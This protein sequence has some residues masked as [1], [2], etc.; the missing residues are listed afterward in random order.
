MKNI[1]FLFFPAIMCN[2]Q[3]NNIKI[4]SEPINITR[5]IIS[6][7]QNKMVSVLVADNKDIIEIFKPNTNNCTKIKLGKK[8]SFKVTCVSCLI[9]QGADS[10]KIYTLDGSTIIMYKNYYTSEEDQNICIK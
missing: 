7:K 10:P 5:K 3:T 1:L 9:Q 4:S 2:C 6:V 8:Y